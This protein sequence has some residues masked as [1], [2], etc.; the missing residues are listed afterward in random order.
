MT[1]I[2]IWR[3]LNK[4]KSKTGSRHANGQSEEIPALAVLNQKLKG[5]EVSSLTM[6]RLAQVFLQAA[7]LPRKHRSLIRTKW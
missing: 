7:F 6:Y 2:R 1:I 5:L 3:R 4:M